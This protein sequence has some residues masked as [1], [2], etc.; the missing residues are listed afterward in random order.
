MQ[1]CLDSPDF[2]GFF[3]PPL[4]H[5][6]L[7]FTVS[8]YCLSSYLFLIPPPSLVHCLSYCFCQDA[9]ACGFYLSPPFLSLFLSLAPSLTLSVGALYADSSVLKQLCS[10]TDPRAETP[11]ASERAG[12]CTVCSVSCSVILKL[13]TV[14]AK[15]RAVCLYTRSS[16]R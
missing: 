15:G 10:G 4:L 7:C 9:H 2:Q 13:C 5:L 12:A 3:F 14:L 6:Y 16:L 8:V 11:Q 1:T